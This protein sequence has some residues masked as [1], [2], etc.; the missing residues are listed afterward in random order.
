MA[1]LLT[2]LVDRQTLWITVSCKLGG[3]TSMRNNSVKLLM[4]ILWE[5]YA[6]IE[7]TL[8]QITESKVW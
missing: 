2:V 3:Y 1:H 8:P 5:R 7:P 4:H 6:K